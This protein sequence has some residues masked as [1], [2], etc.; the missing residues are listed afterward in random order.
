M[1]Y[2][3]RFK[4]TSTPLFTAVL[5]A[6]VATGFAAQA[7]SSFPLPHKTPGQ[8]EVWTNWGWVYNG[9]V[10]FK[11]GEKLESAPSPP[12]KMQTLCSRTPDDMAK[13]LS[14]RSLDAIPAA[15][16]VKQTSASATEQIYTI[17][18]AES[19]PV[20]SMQAEVK[21]MYDAAAKTTLWQESALDPA[22][23][24][25]GTQ[26]TMRLKRLGDC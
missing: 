25:T 8:Y 10:F 7:Q 23:K 13:V 12:T 24:P 11:D 20:R 18:C 2:I 9:A 5:T 14:R 22:M 4:S 6:L 26:Q 15:C 16:Q 19:G 3:P 21:L 1:V 17:A